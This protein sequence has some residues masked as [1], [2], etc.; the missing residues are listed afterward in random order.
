ME[1][2]LRGV[3]CVVIAT[4][5]FESLARELGD[6]KGFS[7]RIVTIEH[8]LGGMELGQVESRARRAIEAIIALLS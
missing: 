5:K 6:L 1:L 8:P 3:P 7:A 4:E 2:E